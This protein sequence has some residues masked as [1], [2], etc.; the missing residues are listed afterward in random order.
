MRKLVRTPP[1]AGTTAGKRWRVVVATSAVVV[2]LSVV[3]GGAVLA[4]WLYD[5]TGARDP[6]VFD[7]DTPG[8]V[9]LV[10]GIREDSPE[11][12]YDVL[13]RETRGNMDRG[14]FV[15]SYEQQ[16]AKTGPVTRVA[17][18]G[19]FRSRDTADG[20]LGSATMQI[21]YKGRRSRDYSAYFR[22]EDREWRIWFTAPARREEG[23]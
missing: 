16:R 22:F 2:L 13:S 21:G 20:A 3:A 1:D 23:E 14:E 7:A 10:T 18:R 4:L 11:A 5:G 19:P 8:I 17:A 12:L 6:R 15:R 9:S